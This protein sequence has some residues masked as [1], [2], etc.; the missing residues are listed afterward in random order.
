MPDK[1]T[2]AVIK[3]ASCD[4]CQ[5]TLLAAEDELLGLTQAIDIIY[6][7]EATSHI[8]P[9]PY[10]IALVEGSITTEDDLKRIR[11]IRAQAR[12][13]VTIGACATSGGIQALR[14]WADCEQMIQSVY[15]SPEYIKVLKHSTPVSEHVNV[16]FELRG[17]PINKQQLIEVIKSLVAGRTPRTPRHSVC[18]DCKRRGTV[19]VM[20]TAG[21]PCLGPATQAGCGALCPA[22][23]RAC[24]GCFGPTAQ[25]NLVSLTSQFSKH[26]VSQ[27][28]IVHNLRTFNANSPEFRSESNRLDT[29]NQEQL[30]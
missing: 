3:L 20:I 5:L 15:P 9:G 14:N 11:Q 21:E 2:V 22:Y 4:G 30:P 7:L 6:F 13:L 1:P 23:D 19:C 28:T 24:Y 18:L 29:T 27:Q 17:C 12:Y 26:R 16:D 8:E 10:D 25:P